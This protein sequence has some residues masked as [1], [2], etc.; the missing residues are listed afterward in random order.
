MEERIDFRVF[1]A[2]SASVVFAASAFAGIRAGLEGYSPEALPLLRFL[3]ASVN[4]AI[5]A[6]LTGMA[7]PRLGD[8]PAIAVAG[9]LAFSVYSVALNRGELTVPA[10]TAGLLIGSIPAFAAI[11]ATLFFRERLGLWGW[12]ASRSASA[13]WL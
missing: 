1:V 6:L 7:L 12:V 8:V 3:G 4:L 13:G 10:G 11:W 5:Y 2:L 9:F